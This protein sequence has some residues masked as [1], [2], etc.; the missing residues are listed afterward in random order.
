MTYKTRLL[1]TRNFP[2]DVMARA[3]RSYDAITNDDDHAMSM[4]EI[5]HLSQEV[6]AIL[7]SG[8]EAFNAELIAG[9]PDSVKMIATFSVGYDHIDVL[10]ATAR[11]IRLSNTP[12]VLTDA[13]ADIAMLC[14]LGAAR[15]AHLSAE[16]LRAGEWKRW[17][18]NQFLGVHV[19][20]K[21]MGI[22]GMG[23]IGQAVARRAKGFDMQIHYHNRRRITAPGL[24]DAIFH[25]TVESFLPECDFL[26]INCPLSAETKYFVNDD[27][28]AKM[29]DR[30][31]IVNTARGGVVEDA[32]LIRGL[33]S[34][35]V[36]AAGLDVFEN[37][38]A[39]NPGYLELDN[40]F[41]LPHIGSATV[42]TRNAMG[43][44]CLDNLD[45]FFA[46]K[47]LPS[48]IKVP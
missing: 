23:R 15:M 18:P 4:S 12:D 13:T 48:E 1:V 7:C 32:A 36:A 35:K 39:L 24:E 33:K 2:P 29:P 9:L 3:T 31:V 37:E 10:A 47:E 41:V 6:D 25:E 20:G 28:I 17:E 16:T 8:T 34:G 46:G 21:R 43:F 11:G 42:E 26:S 22:L 27:S 45:A 40:L 30:T 44:K 38:P 19:S 5:L 14:M